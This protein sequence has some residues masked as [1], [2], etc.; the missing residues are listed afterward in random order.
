MVKTHRF[1]RM[2]F[3]AL[4]FAIITTSVY[5]QASHSE[6][7]KLPLE[8]AWRVEVLF[9]SKVILP[10]VAEVNIGPRSPSEVAGYDQISVTYTADGNVSQPIVFLLSKDGRWLVPFSKFEIGADP[11]IHISGVDR[12]SRGGPKDAPVSIIVFDDLECPYCALFNATLLPAVLDRYKEL[13]RVVYMDYPSEGHPWALRAAVDTACLADQ[14]DAGYWNAVDAIHSRA[15]ELGGKEGS[16]S[17]AN[18]SLDTIVNQIGER[19]HVDA[20]ALKACIQKQNA[21]SV[22]FS[23]RQ[24]EAL[25]IERTPTLFINGA[26]I[27]GAAPIDFLFHMIDTALLAKGKTLPSRKS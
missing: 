8:L 12:P 9:R 22:E 18:D 11:Q 13:V 21:S 27:E 15:S 5:A 3:C 16:L 19:Q 20:T 17:V 10:P 23:Q 1:H 26:K 4:L 14:S 24:G 25:R 7:E 2:A 6:G